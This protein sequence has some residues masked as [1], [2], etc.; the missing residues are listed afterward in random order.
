MT[1]FLKKWKK[2]LTFAALLSCFVNILQLTFPFYMFTIYSNV[3]L[4]Y[5]IFSLSNITVAAFF[6]VMI[7]GLFSYIRS[8]LLALA[9]KDL[10]LSL[11]QDVYSVMVKGCVID[12]K[13]AYQ[14]VCTILRPCGTILPRLRF[15]SCSTPLG[16][17]FIWRLFF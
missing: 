12:S 2:F 14:A 7:L 9:G 6:A 1:A 4:S 5:S 11:R 8:R 17:R 13:R 16:R 15:M 3:V 10:G